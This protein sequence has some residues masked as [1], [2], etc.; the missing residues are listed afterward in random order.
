MRILILQENMYRYLEIIDTLYHVVRG[1]WK[2][3]D[4]DV[5]TAIAAD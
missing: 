1:R 3:I 5:S 4:V 2:F